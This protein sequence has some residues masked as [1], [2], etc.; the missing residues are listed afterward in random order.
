MTEIRNEPLS[1]RF[2]GSDGLVA[3]LRWESG[4]EEWIA[5][6]EPSAGWGEGDT[7]EEAIADLRWWL[8]ELV[9]DVGS[10]DPQMVDPGLYA[11]Y[12]A[13]KKVVQP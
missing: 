4:L 1:H 7:P 8:R 10:Y 2:A 12:E 5:V 3:E 9:T 13:A 6:H 11:Q